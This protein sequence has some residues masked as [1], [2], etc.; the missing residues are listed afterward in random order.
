MATNYTEQYQ[1]SLWEPGDKVLREEFN[2][3]HQKIADAIQGLKTAAES[4]IG[5]GGKTCRI[6]YGSYTGKNVYGSGN[7]NSLTF[8]F[9]PKIVIIDGK[10]YSNDVLV[11]ISGCTMTSSNTNPIT[12]SWSGKSVSW[13]SANNAT[14]QFNASGTYY[15]IAL[16]Y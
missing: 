7:K 2:E 11:L 3:N 4:A 12:V 13:Y 5:T 1:L 10:T 15:Y 14:Y 6:T 16:G 9:E 8:D